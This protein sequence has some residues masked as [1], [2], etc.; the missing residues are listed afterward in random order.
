[1]SIFAAQEVNY[2]IVGGYALMLYCEPRFTRDL[3]IW[4]EASE[5]NAGRVYAALREFGAPL[6]GLS[7]ADFLE[8][9]MLYQIG[10]P[11]VRVDI[12]TSIDGVEFEA[13]WANRVG[14]KFGALT[15]NFISR[16][17]MIRNKR[18]SGRLQ[19]LAD[20]ENLLLG[21]DEGAE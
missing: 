20:V 21:T 4:V 12:L 6:R 15:A 16:R 5:D 19:D 14:R 17:D 13:A 11:P 2:L 18:T 7:P 10:V 1:L 3:D 9:G 8:S